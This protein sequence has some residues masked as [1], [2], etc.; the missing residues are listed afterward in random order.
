MSTRIRVAVLVTLSVLQLAATAS[1]IVRY[2]STLRSGAAYRILSTAFDPVDAF[3]GRYVAVRP[4]IPVIEPISPEMRAALTRI[5]AGETGYVVLGT[6]ANGFAR[7][8]EIHLERPSRGDYLAIGSVWHNAPTQPNGTPAPFTLQLVLTLDRYYMNDAAAPQ[9][10]Q[11]YFEATRRNAD[12]R[13][14]LV[15]R[16]K[17]GVGVIEGLLIDGVPIEQAIAGAAK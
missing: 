3:R 9:A 5:E 15:V 8:S 2:E 6:D 4:G 13:A 1:S 10:Q 7:A 16:V 17:N 11:R 12:S 14:W